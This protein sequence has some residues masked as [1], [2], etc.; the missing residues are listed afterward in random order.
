MHLPD[1][2]VRYDIVSAYDISTV[3][4]VTRFDEDPV[5][6]II[7]LKKPTHEGSRPVQNLIIETIQRCDG[8]M[9]IPI[10]HF[11]ETN[12][13][14]VSSRPRFRVFEILLIIKHRISDVYFATCL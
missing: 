2:C 1:A 5:K 12:G 11:R 8:M 4:Q 13:I 14:K 9:K 7:M 10:R 6:G 3:S